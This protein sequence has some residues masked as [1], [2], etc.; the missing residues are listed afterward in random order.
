MW[1]M[2]PSEFGH[3]LEMV[4]SY[5]VHFPRKEL[6]TGDLIR[7][8]PLSED[9]LLEILE[10]AQHSGIQKL[11]IANNDSVTKY[12]SF[13]KFL[14]FLDGWYEANGLHVALAKKNETDGELPQKRC[15]P[16]EDSGRGHKGD[17][18]RAV[19]RKSPP[20][21]NVCGHG[22]GTHPWPEDKCY[23]KKDMKDGQSGNEKKGEHKYDKRV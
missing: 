8:K 12:N 9:E 21:K 23:C 22:G 5:L 1:K 15:R 10:E 20:H 2:K 16:A 14:S 7:S 17:K 11:M 6:D 13:N 19:D 18:K 4:N 3:R